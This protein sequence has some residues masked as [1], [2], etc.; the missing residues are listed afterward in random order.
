MPPRAVVGGR[1]S[2]GGPLF[3]VSLWISGGRNKPLYVFGHFDP[4]TQLGYGFNN[5]PYTNPSV[6]I[7]LEICSIYSN[8]KRLLNPFAHW[9][10]PKQH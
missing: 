5:G 8:R 1:M 9:D 6:H 7:M 2:H 10:Y 4:E 3:V